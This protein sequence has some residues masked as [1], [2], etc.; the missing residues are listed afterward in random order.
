M[1]LTVV[2]KHIINLDLPPEKRWIPLVKEYKDTILEVYKKMDKILSQVT[3]SWGS[4]G[5]W[6]A[7]IT[8]SFYGESPLYYKE[9]KS[10]ADELN[11]PVAK[12]VLLQLCYECFSA[13]TSIIIDDKDKLSHPI[14]VRTMDWDDT[15]LRPL[16]VNVKFVK[17]GNMLFEGTTWVGYVGILTGVKPNIASISVNY[18][19][20]KDGTIWKNIWNTLKFHYPIGYLVRECLT[21]CSNYKS[22]KENLE[23]T[24]I[25]APCYII[26]TGS[27]PHSGLVIVRDRRKYD[28]YPID[29]KKYICQ[30]NIDPK[31]MNIDIGC[32]ILMSIERT[33]LAWDKCDS[34]L[35]VLSY[36][37]ESNVVNPEGIIRHFLEFPILNNETI[38]ANIMSPT[39]PNNHT[40]INASWIIN[41]KK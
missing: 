15:F 18:R 31:D 27:L 12:I 5:L 24:I 19:R 40:Y 20:T 7:Q 34:L 33:H 3:G 28:S 6:T 14:H 11:L 38:Y 1:S 4:I 41:P 26:L 8:I 13:C 22:L 16:T 32:N 2:P 9:L 39:G 17:N 29:N 10:I 23:K 30:T 36:D 21:H 25:I 35:S 37:P